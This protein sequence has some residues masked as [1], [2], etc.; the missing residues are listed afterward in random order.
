MD[1]VENRETA[2][3]DV[4]VSERLQPIHAKTAPAGSLPKSAYQSRGFSRRVTS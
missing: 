1:T 2:A 3:G 4:T